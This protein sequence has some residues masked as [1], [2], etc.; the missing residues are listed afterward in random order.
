LIIQIPCLNEAESLPA[1]LAA[2]PKEIPGVDVIETLIIDDGSTDNTSEVARAHGVQHIVRLTTRKG[3][4]VVFATGLDACLKRGAD[5]I[6]NTDADGQYKGEDIPRLIEPIVAGKADI[7]IGNRDIENVEQFS[8]IKKRL[9]RLGSWVVAQLAQSTVRDTTTGF[10][11]YNREAALRLNII[12]EYTY[13]LE[14]IIQAENKNLAVAN[15]TI[16]TNPVERPSR[17]F[18]SI[19]EYIKRS[20]ITIVRIYAMFNPFSIFLRMGTLFMIISGLLGLRFLFDYLTTGG[21]GKIQSLILVAILSIIGFQ[22]IIV[23]IVADLISANRRLI[24]DMLLRVK[25]IEL[26]SKS[27]EQSA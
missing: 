8:W 9:Q 10:R 18:K 1:T 16:N 25:K 17:L 13:T 14:S 15:I 19:P 21:E 2:L 5:I 4:A 6:V 7:V 22:L 27:D 26:K 3:L 20:L 12:S 11:A 24:E 23:G